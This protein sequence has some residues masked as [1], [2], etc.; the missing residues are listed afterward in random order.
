MGDTGA[1]VLAHVNNLAAYVQQ[2]ALG[3]LDTP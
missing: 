3:A 1:A 2:R